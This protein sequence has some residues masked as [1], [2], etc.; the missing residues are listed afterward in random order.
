M[1]LIKSKIPDTLIALYAIFGG[2]AFFSIQTGRLLKP[3]ASEA[4]FAQLPL[5]RFNWGFVWSDTLMAGPALLIGGLLMLGRRDAIKRLGRLLTFAGFAIN[6]YAMIILW[7][8]LAA[9]GEPMRAGELG[10]NIVLTF[11]G[12]LC[13]IRIAF[14]ITKA[15]G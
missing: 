9:I 3:A 6:L 7:I 14:Q 8:G 12:V 13:M 10:M 4:A 15:A 1:N 11:L 2:A 5:G